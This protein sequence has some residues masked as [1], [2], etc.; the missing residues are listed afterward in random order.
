MNEGQC[1]RGRRFE[2]LFKAYAADVMAYCSWRAGS[3]SDAQDAT[4]EVFLT[5]W[6]RVDAIP[7]GDAARV[8]LYATARRVLATS[9]ARLAAA[10][11]WPR[12]SRSPRRRRSHGAI[13]RSGS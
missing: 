2:A 7:E 12:G 10:R 8:W 6:R 1:E 5:A 3:A 9:A 11:R 4:A 13:R